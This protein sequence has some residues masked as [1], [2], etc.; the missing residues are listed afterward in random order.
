MF[1]GRKDMNIYK[2][3]SQATGVARTLSRSAA[4]TIVV[5]QAGEHRFVT[6]L[7]IMDAVD[8]RLL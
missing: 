2:T 7:D 8:Q 1:E 6:A 4:C 3:V 5:N